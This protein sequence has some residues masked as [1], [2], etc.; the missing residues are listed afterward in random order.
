MKIDAQ[1]RLKHDAKKFGL[2]RL[3]ARTS[4]DL[5][6]FESW[7]HR[8]TWRRR[9]QSVSYLFDI[10][11]LNLALFL[12]KFYLFNFLVDLLYKTVHSKSKVYSKPTHKLP[13]QK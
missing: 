2:R 10:T 5:C 12:L 3:V 9:L 8:H 6:I 11:D 4:Y 7:G 13:R 1:M